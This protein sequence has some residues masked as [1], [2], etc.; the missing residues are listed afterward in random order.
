MMKLYHLVT[1]DRVWS[2]RTAR[3]DST[4]IPLLERRMSGIL[5]SRVVHHPAVKRDVIIHLSLKFESRGSRGSV[6][7]DPLGFRLLPLPRCWVLPS[8]CLSPSS[9]GGPS[10][11]RLLFLCGYCFTSA[12]HVSQSFPTIMELPGCLCWA[13]PLPLSGSRG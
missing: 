6:P 8:I 5:P 11:G 2:M 9:P 10:T 1:C 7:E 12:A 3:P 4:K 13:G